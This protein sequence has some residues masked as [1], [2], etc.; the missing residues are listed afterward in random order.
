MRHHVIKFLSTM[1][2]SAKQLTE[3]DVLEW[4]NAK[5]AASGVHP[6]VKLSDASLASGVYILHLIKAVAPRSVDLA[7]V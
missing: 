6:V 3:K 2:G 5:V 4:A 1:S 7:Q